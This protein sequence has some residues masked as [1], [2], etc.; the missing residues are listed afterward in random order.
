MPDLRTRILDA[1]L[2]CFLEQ[3]IEQTTVAR[4]RAVSGVSN[5][6]L[7][8]HF[9]TKEAIADALYVAAMTD[10][11]RGHWALLERRPRS[12]RSALRATVRHQL[13]WTEANPERARFLYLRGHI[14]WQSPAGAE[15]AERNRELGD[16]YRAW[17]EP[18]ADELRPASMLVLT[19]IVTGPAHAIAQRWLAGQVAAPLRSFADELGDAA[20]AALAVAPPARR[21]TPARAVPAAG[22]IQVQLLDADGT[23]IAVGEGTAD[24][25][26]PE[27]G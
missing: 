13:E 9:P 24:L 19:A 8:H 15:L 18:W 22:R 16:A 25:S 3:G 7:F 14:D 2:T 20:H 11:Q 5:G 10:F 12:L 27:T 1:A 4:I 21:R 17:L 26:A 6:A 23:V